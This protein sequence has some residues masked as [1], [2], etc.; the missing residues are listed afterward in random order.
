MVKENIIDFLRTG[1]LTNFPFGSDRQTILDKLGNN[2]DWIVTISKKDKRPALIKYDQTE[3]YFNRQDNQRLYGVQVTYSQPA[4]KKG[5]HME[6]GDLRQ[7][8]DYGQ[9]K[10]FL[11]RNNVPFIETSSD[12]DTG[13][14]VIKTQGQVS[15]FFSDENRLEKFGRFIYGNEKKL[16]STRQ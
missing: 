12:F 15:F 10:D 3:F 5:L 11:T 2:P 8:L 16:K 4:D 1:E 6:Y 14:Q 9:T 7:A 13:T